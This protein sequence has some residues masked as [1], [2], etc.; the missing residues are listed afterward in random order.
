MYKPEQD[1]FNN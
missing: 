1:L